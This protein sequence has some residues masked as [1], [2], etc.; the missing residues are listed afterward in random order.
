MKLGSNSRKCQA[1]I[2]VIK[3]HHGCLFTYKSLL[4]HSGCSTCLHSN[5]AKLSLVVLRR[6]FCLS[7]CLSVKRW[8]GL[9]QRCRQSWIKM[10]L[11]WTKLTIWKARG[12]TRQASN[13]G[14][15]VWKGTWKEAELSH[16]G[17]TG[18]R[19]QCRADLCLRELMR[20]LWAGP[21]GM[22]ELRRC[23]CSHLNLQDKQKWSWLKSIHVSWQKIVHPERIKAAF[24]PISAQEHSR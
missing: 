9:S 12:I 13:K 8:C 1:R 6:H 24:K 20:E 17:K 5:T 4:S 19:H 11:S 23:C 7:V 2:Y 10:R 18:W 3:S 22:S 14:K 21:Q 15:Q 16:T